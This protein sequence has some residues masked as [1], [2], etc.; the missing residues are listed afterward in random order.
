MTTHAFFSNSL[1]LNT[2]YYGSWNWI[3]PK[4]LLQNYSR[5]FLFFIFYSCV[6]HVFRMNSNQ[7]K[8]RT[9]VKRE[10]VLHSLTCLVV[11]LLGLHTTTRSFFQI[12]HFPRRFLGYIIL[13]IIE[14]RCDFLFHVQIQ[15]TRTPFFILLPFFP[16]PNTMRIH[17]MRISKILIG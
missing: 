3:R 2:F 15:I 6:S 12:N 9:L 4:N 11:A 10:R 7:L 17:I 1:L 8:V 5:F 14:K 16:W 13:N